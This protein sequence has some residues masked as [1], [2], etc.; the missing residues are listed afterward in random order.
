M[1]SSDIPLP[2]LKW[3]VRWAGGGGRER[4]NFNYLPRREEGESEKLRKVGGSMVQGLVI[5]KGGGTLF[6]FNF[7]KV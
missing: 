5:L 3:R 4:V 6:L 2:F 7:F 1:L